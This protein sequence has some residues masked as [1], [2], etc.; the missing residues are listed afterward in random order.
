M[1]KR[2]LRKVVKTLIAAT[3][4]VLFWRGAWGLMDLYLHPTNPL[5]SYII[6]IVAG[7]AIL[8]YSKKFFDGLL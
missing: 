2:V 8:Y 5:V 1:K 7:L 4:V 3:G 6:S